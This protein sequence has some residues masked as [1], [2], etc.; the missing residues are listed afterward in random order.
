MK[1]GDRRCHFGTKN[2]P[3]TLYLAPFDTV[4]RMHTTITLEQIRT[5][6]QVKNILA[7]KLCGAVA[8]LSAVLTIR[9]KMSASITLCTN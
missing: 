7:Q 8:S 9:P 2:R 5:R 4:F 3:F 6:G 1:L